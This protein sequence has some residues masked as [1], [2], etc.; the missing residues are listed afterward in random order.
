MVKPGPGRLKPLAR[1]IRNRVLSR[2]ASDVLGR[3]LEQEIFIKAKVLSE[4]GCRAA[5]EGHES[6]FGSTMISVPLSSLARV[7][8]GDLDQ[9]ARDQLERAVAGSVRVRLRAMRIARAEVA[10][11]V[12]HRVLGTAQ[13]ES[14]VRLTRDQLFIDVDLEVPLGVSFSAKRR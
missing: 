8:R 7:T 3:E 4:G 9:N 12:P 10:R 11:R 14:R 1:A 13:V 5:P 2:H 6:Y